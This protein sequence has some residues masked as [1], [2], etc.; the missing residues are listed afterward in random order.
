MNRK[1][2]LKN[3]QQDIEI[4]DILLEDTIKSAAIKTK[5]KTASTEDSNTFV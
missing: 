3:I 5:V 4:Q 2:F 1:F